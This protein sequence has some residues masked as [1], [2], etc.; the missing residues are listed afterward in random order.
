M[1]SK[2]GSG[3]VRT[4]V[5][6]ITGDDQAARRRFNKRLDRYQGSNGREERTSIWCVGRSIDGQNMKRIKK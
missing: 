3:R 1:S 2:I 5:V 4:G 6:E